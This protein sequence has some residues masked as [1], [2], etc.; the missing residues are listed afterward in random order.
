MPSDPTRRV[1][2]STYHGNTSGSVAYYA[3]ADPRI[4]KIFEKY[5]KGEVDEEQVEHAITKITGVARVHADWK[6]AG[7]PDSYITGPPAFEDWLKRKPTE[8]LRVYG[9]PKVI[10]RILIESKEAQ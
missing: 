1:K 3:A 7:A 4:L 10:T 9:S 5:D 8:Y 2:V 6:E